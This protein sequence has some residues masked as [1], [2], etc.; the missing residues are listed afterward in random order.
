ML[1]LK[2]LQTE[3]RTK[4][5]VAGRNS[6]RCFRV[7]HLHRQIDLFFP[8]S[9]SGRRSGVTNSLERNRRRGGFKSPRRRPSR[10]AHRA[11]RSGP[12]IGRE[13]VYPWRSSSRRRVDAPTPVPRGPNLRLP[14]TDT[15]K[16]PY[17]L[18]VARGNAESDPCI[19]AAL[20]DQGPK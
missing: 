10:Q 13:R 16:V 15:H 8:L 14:S 19:H 1:L 4:R 20:P 3:C 18:G 11:A 7:G 9:G 2:H 12:F 6:L 5:A 17:V